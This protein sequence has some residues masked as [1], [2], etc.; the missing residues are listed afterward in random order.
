[1]PGN[2]HITAAELVTIGA[3]IGFIGALA[4]ILRYSR[5]GLRMRAGAENPTLARLRGVNVDVTSC[6]AWCIGGGRLH[7]GG[8]GVLN[9]GTYRSDDGES[10]NLCISGHPDWRAG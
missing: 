6:I 4:V 8:S 9:A 5:F 1:L 2:A 3:A 10:G 7:A